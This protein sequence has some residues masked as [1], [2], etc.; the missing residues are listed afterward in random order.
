MREK[1]TVR[2]RDGSAA[3]SARAGRVVS[4]DD[5]VMTKRETAEFAKLSQRT[6][7]RL[8]VLK[9]GPRRVK[10]GGS[11]RYLRSDVLDWLREGAAR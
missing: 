10:L 7:E 4:A 3:S 1:C 6:L 11:V 5:F 2:T 8:H 9:K